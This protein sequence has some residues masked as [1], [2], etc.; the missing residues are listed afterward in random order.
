[1]ITN[2]SIN[3]ISQ[4]G[5][6]M[7]LPCKQMT[8]ALV[9]LFSQ[10]SPIE[11]TLVLVPLLLHDASVTKDGSYRNE[12]INGFCKVKLAG[13]CGLSEVYPR[14]AMKDDLCNV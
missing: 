14:P 8:C 12:N 4:L 2:V 7:T 6:F 1:M 13:V 5:L 9:P 3:K 10:T 11:I